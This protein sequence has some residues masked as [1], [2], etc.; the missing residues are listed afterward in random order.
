ME[1]H[2]NSP[3]WHP[4][5]GKLCEVQLYTGEK[6]IAELIPFNLKYHYKHVVPDRWRRPDK[7]LT[8]KQ[9]WIDDDTVAKWR[10]I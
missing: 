9:R 10:Y 2:T 6:Y 1:W 3:V 5:Y 4:Q 7:G 8:K